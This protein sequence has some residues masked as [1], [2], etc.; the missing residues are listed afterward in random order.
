MKASA[1]LKL[2]KAYSMFPSASGEFVLPAI[3]ESLTPET[4]LATTLQMARLPPK[5]IS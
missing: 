2:A 1:C 4:G 5:T 3:S